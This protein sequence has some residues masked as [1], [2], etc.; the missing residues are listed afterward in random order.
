MYSPHRVSNL[1]LSGL[2][3]SALTTKL[4]YTILL[5]YYSSI[6]LQINTSKTSLITCCL[7][8]NKEQAQIGGGGGCI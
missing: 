5:M 7:F 1:R 2:Y 6:F 8:E 3:P 4:L